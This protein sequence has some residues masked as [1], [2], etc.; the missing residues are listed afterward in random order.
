[1]K[2]LILV[3]AVLLLAYQGWNHFSEPERERVAVHDQVIMYSLTTCG[4]C[5]AKRRELTNAGIAFQEVF[6]DLDR[7]RQ[8][9]LNAKLEAAGYPPRRYG[10]PILDV[11][12]FMLPNNPDLGEIR[13]YL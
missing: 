11:K 10:T 3:A 2:R 5:K 4:Y 7:S 1:M 6:I 12:G 9:E 13:R 8:D